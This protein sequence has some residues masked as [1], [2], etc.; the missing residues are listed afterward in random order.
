MDWTWA[1][2]I[3]LLLL[4]LLCPLIMIGM[5]VGGWIFGR[6]MIGGGHS[7]HGMMMCHGGS[8]DEARDGPQHAGGE[9]AHAGS[10]LEE[11]KAERER[12]D[13]LIER[14]EREQV[15]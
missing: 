3:P 10:L 15:R 11:L 14:V 7:G 2:G 4:V 8:H 12:L 1:I 6:R 9:A 13:H 5:I